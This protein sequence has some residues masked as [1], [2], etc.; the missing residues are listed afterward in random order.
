M[1]ALSHSIPRVSRR[2]ETRCEGMQ[3]EADNRSSARSTREGAPFACN[4]C[5]IFIPYKR[6]AKDSRQSP[7]IH[8]NSP[9][10]NPKI[11]ILNMAADNFKMYRGNCHCTR[12]VYEL[13]SPE[14]NEYFRCTCSICFKLGAAWL[15]ADNDNV[16]FVKGNIDALAV[17]TFN[18]G[19]YKHMVCGLPCGSWF[20]SVADG[21][22]NDNQQFCPD[23]GTNLLTSNPTLPEPKVAINV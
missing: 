19:N 3:L 22:C 4:T 11:K 17:Y 16:N 23:C 12:F 15:L 7:A 18:E 6:S 10:S 5:T 9:P 8:P 1:A 2:E 20:H 21:V 14:I 13:K